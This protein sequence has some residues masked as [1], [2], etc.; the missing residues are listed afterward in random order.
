MHSHALV[1]PPNGWL[2][3]LVDGMTGFGN[4]GVRR[5]RGGEMDSNHRSLAEFGN[6][7][8]AGVSFAVSQFSN[9]LSERTCHA[10]CCAAAP[11]NGLFAGNDVGAIATAHVS[12]VADLTIRCT[13]SQ[14][15]NASNYH[16]YNKKKTPSLRVLRV[17]RSHSATRLLQAASVRVFAS[18]TTRN[19]QRGP[20]IE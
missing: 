16:F 20:A 3:L 8:L 17:K 12:L 19:A 2:S 1:L 14:A 18:M 9:G 15:T 10:L 6:F 13:D 11:A 7:V 4:R 5:L